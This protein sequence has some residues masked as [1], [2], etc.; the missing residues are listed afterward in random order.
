MH[1]LRRSASDRRSRSLVHLARNAL[2]CAIVAMS[3]VVVIASSSARAVEPDAAREDRLANEIVPQLMVGDPIWLSTPHRARVLALYTQPH[4]PTHD[5]VIVVHGLGVHPDWSLIGTL[6][7]D[8]ADRGFATLSVQMP[9][10]AAG[11]TREAYV[12]LFAQAG[13]RLTAATKWLRD[14][15]YVRIAIVS[16]SMGAMMVN[17][18]LAQSSEHVDAWIPVGLMAAFAAPPREPV[19]DVVAERDFPE[20]LETSKGR[21]LQLPHDRCSSS[22]MIAGTDHYFEGASRRLLEA[23]ATFLARA[24]SDDCR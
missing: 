5:A 16:H 10:L 13:E 24:F 6:R 11:A 1:R 23:V 19:L 20:V 9:V 8:L 21:A 3:L 17:A 2:T 15:G 14:N 4:K 12:D 18:W 7:S 22:T